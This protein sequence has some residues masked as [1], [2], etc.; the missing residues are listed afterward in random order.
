M[1][2]PGSRRGV[3]SAIVYPNMKFKF[4]WAYLLSVAGCKLDSQGLPGDVGLLVL[5]CF[6]YC[7][8][9]GGVL[10][11]HPTGGWLNQA[12]QVNYLQSCSVWY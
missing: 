4:D 7:L 8:L 10:A 3:V 12:R 9:P 11:V 2:P 6:R 5:F 1:Y